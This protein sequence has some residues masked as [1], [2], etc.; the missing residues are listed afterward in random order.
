MNE[1]SEIAILVSVS[2]V[3]SLL[4]YVPFALNIHA[5]LG[6]QLPE[7]GISVIERYYD[8]PL[9]VVVSKTFYAPS[10]AIYGAI[11]LPP[12]YFAAH[13]PGYPVVIWLFSLATSPFI[14]MVVA[15]LVISAGAVVVFYTLASRF[16]LAHDPFSSSLLFLFFPPRWFLYRSVGASEPLFVL[17]TLLMLY[18]LKKDAPGKATLCGVAAALTRIW[19]VLTF[20]VLIGSWL[21]N[22]KLTPK[23][24][25]VALAIPAS[26][27]SI[28]AWYAYS[29][30]NF[31]AFFAVNAGYLG[32]P[33]QLIPARTVLPETSSAFAGEWYV[34][35]FFLY[36]LGIVRL[37]EKR[38]RELFLYALVMFLPLL[39]VF[40]ED[41]SRYLLPIAPVALIIGFDELIPKKRLYFLIPFALLCVA[42]YLYCVAVLPTNVL[43]LDTFGHL[44]QALGV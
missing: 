17:A 34:V 13:L 11:G 37:Y 24:V 25:L 4:L 32:A 2:V 44:S 35:L 22:K 29:L 42:A 19:G 20:I 9:Y 40:H 15:N 8:G 27:L 43:P 14:A 10:A 31:F 6:V 23:R 7:T 39:F 18:A 1:R 16:K 36:G 28:F 12:A 41:I 30:G 33:L 21:W 3:S 38:F 26:L 5:I